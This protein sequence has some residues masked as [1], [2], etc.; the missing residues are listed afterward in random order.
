VTGRA[1]RFADALN[2][3]ESTGEAGD[4]LAQFGDGAELSRPEADR[5]DAST[6]APAFWDAYRAQFEE[7]STTFSAVDENGDLGVLEWRSTGTLS[8]GRSIDYRGVSLLH[9]GE[10][11][12]VHRFATYYDTAAFLE[13]TA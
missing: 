9:F 12:T 4:L 10:D 2:A 3:F 5:G 1:Q 6:D 11:D 8:T 7:L 13:P